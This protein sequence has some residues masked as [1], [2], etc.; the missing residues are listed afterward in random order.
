[1][2]NLILCCAMLGVWAVSSPL[3]NVTA[4]P[5]D[6]AAQLPAWL[7]LPGTA[8]IME[9]N[10]NGSIGEETREGSVSALIYEDSLTIATRMK[11][12]LA[13]Q[14]F[15]I[16]ERATDLDRSTGAASVFEAANPSNGRTV[17]AVALDTPSGGLL[18]IDFS[19]P[20]APAVASNF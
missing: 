6:P 4:S 18:R 20:A 9:M 16:E 1:M 8:E 10:F 14:G 11:T 12:R 7:A 19:D 2:R 5:P 3:A 13:L 17:T 15:M